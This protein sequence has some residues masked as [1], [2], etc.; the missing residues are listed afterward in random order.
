[1]LLVQVPRWLRRS[2]VLLRICSGVNDGAEVR[3]PVPAEQTEDL[4][5]D[6]ARQRFEVWVVEHDPTQCAVAQELYRFVVCAH[7]VPAVDVT[8]T[9]LVVRGVVQILRQKAVVV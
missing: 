2:I 5:A 9:A 3:V 7:E 8:S 1:M 6:T 4:L